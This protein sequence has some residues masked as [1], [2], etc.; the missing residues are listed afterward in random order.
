M[1]DLEQQA[2]SSVAANDVCTN[3]WQNHSLSGGAAATVGL[4]ISLLSGCCV[5]S[6]RVGRR[7]SSC[8]AVSDIYKLNGG[9]LLYVTG[10]ELSMLHASLSTCEID[11]SKDAL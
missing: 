8:L 3:I 4:K 2:I 1:E 5:A 11:C 7:S 6:W 9:I 10:P